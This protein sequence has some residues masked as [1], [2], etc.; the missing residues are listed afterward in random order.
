[1]S[2]ADK[3]NESAS[4]PTTQAEKIVSLA[5]E[6]YRFGQTPKLEPFAV[7]RGGPNVALWLNGSGGALKDAIALAYRAQHNG[8]MNSTAFADALCTLR[9]E[10]Q[11][12]PPEPVSIRVGRASGGVWIDLG[13]VDGASVFIGRGGGGWV[14]KPHA[15]I[16]FQ[17]T[18]LTGELPTPTYG[19]SLEQLRE[20][21][22][23]TQETWPVLLAWMVAALIPEMPHPILMLGGQQGTGKT[24]A[25]RYICGVFDRSDAPIRSQ[26]RD[27]ESWSM[28]VANSWATVVD[29]VSTIPEWWSDALCKAVTGDGFVRRTLYTNNEVSVLSFKR[30]VALTSIDVG[31]L[32]GDLAERLLL[33]DLD[34][35][36]EDKRKSELDLDQAYRAVH[37]SIFG[38]LLTLAGKV[39]YQLPKVQ[40]KRLPRM[41]DFAKVCAA[42]DAVL[43]TSSL[44]L[45]LDQRKRIACDVLDADQVGS[46][47][48]SWMSR[49]AES[50]SGS[51]SQ[52]MDEIKPEDTDRSW[53][54]SPRGLGSRVRR[55]I[56]ALALQG[57]LVTP[58]HRND[59]RR[60]FVVQLTAQTAQQPENA[61]GCEESSSSGRAVETTTAQPPIDSPSENACLVDDAVDSGRSGGSGDCLPTNLQGDWG[62]T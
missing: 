27:P 33:V 11:T 61:M 51:A 56:P 25:A 45:F 55:L 43:G 36:S 50:W 18:A 49:R 60:E 42:M 40:L 29:N 53:P 59:R 2:I 14:V 17:R 35:I 5:Q 31:A 13:R 24:T 62:E 15:E 6:L 12:M 21:L 48:V 16:L 19:G 41:A 20:L 4:E 26:P 28:S 9:G 3:H 38:A 46:A 57:I 47:I 58:P 23:V 54:R 52:L 32:R 30:V 44:A 7:K 34:P 39:F 10:A 1:M 37:A 8:V 22:N